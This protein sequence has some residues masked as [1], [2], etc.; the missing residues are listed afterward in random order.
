MSLTIDNLSKLIEQYNPTKL[1]NEI[2]NKLDRYIDSLISKKKDL[3]LDELRKLISKARNL[4]P[5][6]DMAA[7]KSV[8]AQI[9]LSLNALEKQGI[10]VPPQILGFL[11]KMTGNK[12]KLAQGPDSSAGESINEQLVSFSDT[13]DFDPLKSLMPKNPNDPKDPES[14]V[15]TVNTTA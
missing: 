15:N 7:L 10:E 5:R 12:N 1:I 11:N 2:Y 14:P 3:N 8:L 6:T 9:G 4:S 13:P